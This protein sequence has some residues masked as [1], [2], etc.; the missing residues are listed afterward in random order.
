MDD[1]KCNQQMLL[2]ACKDANHAKII[3]IGTLFLMF[4]PR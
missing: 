2:Y 1:V 4:I 3:S